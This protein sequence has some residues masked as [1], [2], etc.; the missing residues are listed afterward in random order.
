MRILILRIGAMGDVLHALPAVAALRSALPAAHLG[1]AIDPRWL[2]LLQDSRGHSPVPEPR[3]IDTFHAVDTKL[4]KQQPLSAATARSILSLRS[5]LRAA[6]YDLCID[7]QGTIRSAI[8]GRL[9]A[10]PDFVGSA[11][12]REAPA[13]LLYSRRIT[14]SAIHVVE[15]AAQLVSAALHRELRPLPVVLPQD[16]LAEAWWRQQ[17]LEHQPFV[18]LVPQAGWGAKQWPAD[19]F[20]DLALQLA[21]R[22]F[23]VLVNQSRPDDP[24]AAAVVTA[25]HGAATAIVTDLPQLIALT[26]RAALVVAGDTGPLHLAAALNR[27]VLALFG[28]TDPART[29]PWNMGPQNM[30]SQNMGPQNTPARALRHPSSV[31]N[32]RRHPTTERGLLQLSTQTVADAAFE[33]LHQAQPEQPS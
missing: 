30:D 28:P 10:A 9:A 16:P 19:R 4:W 17:L 21:G 3:L 11:H 25:A 18:F 32:H 24:R 8:V 29:G 20:G 27:P 23:R 5:Q 31:T 15:Q 12:P 13:R 22:G 6:A 14:T 1:W 33:L 2:P 26:R 7:L